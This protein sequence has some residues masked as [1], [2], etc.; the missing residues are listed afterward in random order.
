MEPE[1]SG[2]LTSDFT[3]SKVTKIVWYW[4]KNRG[5]VHWNRTGSPEM[6]A[7]APMFK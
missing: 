4:H 5:I 7:H 3:Q 1:E 6:E 2:S